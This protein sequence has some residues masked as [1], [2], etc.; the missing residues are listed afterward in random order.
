MTELRENTHLSG[1]ALIRCMG[2]LLVSALLFG[3]VYAAS[4]SSIVS[5][6]RDGKNLTL[7]TPGASGNSYAP[8]W[9]ADRWHIAFTSIRGGNPEIY[10]MTAD[11]RNVT[12]ITTNLSSDDNPAFSADGMKIA[13]NSNREMP[14]RNQIFSVTSNGMTVT[15]LTNDMG[16][17]YEPAYSPDGLK[18]AYSSTKNMTH[19]IYTMNPDGSQVTQ[20]TFVP[21]MFAS[22]S[23]SWSP[24]SKKIAFS[25]SMAGN[26]EIYTMYA[27]GSRVTRLT[28]NMSEDMEPAWSPRGSEI[29]F[30]SYR[31][32][33]RQIYRMTPDGLGVTGIATDVAG[34][35]YQPSWS[36]DGFTLAFTYL[37]NS[38]PVPAANFTA[39]P[40][41]GTAPLTVRFTD[42]STNSPT[43]WKWTFGDGSPVNSTQKNPVHTYTAA[44]TYAVTLNATN[45]MG[46]NTSTKTA[47]IT[48]TGG[49]APKVTGVVPA[50]GARGKTVQITN[51]SG[52]NFRAGAK[53]FLNKSTSVS[54]TATNVTVVSSQKITCTVMIPAGSVIGPWNI[55]VK[56][57]DGKYG[58]K[59]NAFMVR[60]AT[61][62]TV[63]GITPASGK[64]GK[65]VV[66]TNL[67]G[68]GFVGTPKPTVQL[69]KSTRVIPAT[70]VTVVSAK[71]ITCTFAL[72]ANA[73]AGAWNLRVTNADGQAGAKASAFTVIA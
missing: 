26:P 70:N 68:T 71:K 2:I 66:V 61:V 5:M 45:G 59:V 49:Q 34:E 35:K 36:P 32:G 10:T 23:P 56:N 15:R 40:R 27:N 18:I 9:S 3:T 33:N 48:V 17:N 8:S 62:P 24:D 60:A 65:L 30:T 7:L 28:N 67:S 51:L 57:T 43:A 44:G 50:A 69:V 39:V 54:L 42:I 22:H 38:L 46:S 13:F 64:R 1:K 47:Y 11:G 31:S 29:A 55:T 20:I 37:S 21:P 14:M 41:T 6:T 19:Q 58:T 63:T 53:V 12:R 72:P 73:T 16:D 25:S 4:T 52:T